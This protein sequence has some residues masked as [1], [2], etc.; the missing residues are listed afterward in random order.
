M[1][2]THS[3]SPTSGDENAKRLLEGVAATRASVPRG[4]LPVIV[5]HGTDDGLIPPAFS[6]APY[7]AA[8][9]AAGR[10]GSRS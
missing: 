10:A 7:V 3:P 4:G 2:H 6:S 8:A 9:R 1:A 5:I